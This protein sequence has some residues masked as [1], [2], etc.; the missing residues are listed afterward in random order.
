MNFLASTKM[1]FYYEKY[2]SCERMARVSK[3]LSATHRTEKYNSA[4]G[5]TRDHAKGA[6]TKAGTEKIGRIGQCITSIC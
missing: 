6:Q 5:K 3:K 2:D 4:T 1:K